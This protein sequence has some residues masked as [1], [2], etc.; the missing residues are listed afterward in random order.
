LEQPFKTRGIL[1]D[2]F[3]KLITTLH[4]YASKANRV[5][6]DTTEA[7]TMRN[8]QAL[9]SKATCNQGLQRGFRGIELFKNELLELRE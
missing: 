4:T 7:V 2:E 1:D 3:P 5:D 9:Q 8:Q 6:S